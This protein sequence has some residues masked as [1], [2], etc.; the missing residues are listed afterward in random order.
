MITGHQDLPTSLAILR[1]IQYRV[2]RSHLP[3]GLVFRVCTSVQHLAVTRCLLRTH[4]HWPQRLPAASE[5]SGEA[6]PL[7]CPCHLGAARLS[8][9]LTRSIT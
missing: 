2:H 4:T 5:R 3:A 1:F 6:P 7:S 9:G 8:S